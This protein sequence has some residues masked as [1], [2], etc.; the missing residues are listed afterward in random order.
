[1]INFKK[2]SITDIARKFRNNSFINTIYENTPVFIQNL[3]YSS[4]GFFKY[5]EYKRLEMS[6][7][8]YD[9]E[10]KLSIN[11]I[12]KGQV[13]KLKLLLSHASENSVYYNKLLKKSNLDINN[14]KSID[15]LKKIP[16]LDKNIFKENYELIKVTN[17]DKYSPIAMSSGGT[18][19]TSLN[20]LMDK[21]TYLHKE[22]QSIHHW[23]RHGYELGKCNTVMYRAGLII[24]KGKKVANPWRIDYPRK[25][26]YLSSYYASEELYEQYYKLL[27]KWKPKYIHLLPSAV[28]L[29]AKYLNENNL[30]IKLDKA[31]SS[32]ETLYDFQ[33]YEIEKAFQCSIVD[34]YGHIEPGIYVAGQCEEGH[35]HIYTNDVI[36]EVLEDGSLL[37]T[38]LNN[39]SMPFIRYKV[40]DK[41]DGLHDNCSCGINTPYFKTINGR[42]SSIIYTADGRVISSIGFDQ[43]F[44]GNNIRLGQI[45]QNKKGALK[46]NLVVE[47]NYNNNDRDAIISKLQDRV[48]IDTNI[49]VKYLDDIPKAKSGKY[50]LVISHIK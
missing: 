26:I 50:N 45:I 14:I 19:G 9:F 44:R 35:Y 32:S 5:K 48:G 1:M 29:F 2:N 31:F 24:P 23:K 6:L 37:E 42:D 33:K 13:E 40:G 10:E 34:D 39:Y 15:E 25:M 38:S 47:S 17:S 22:C 36:A 27:K 11:D 30:I 20:F 8:E 18:T 21:K 49:E 46:L 3:I 16:I 28:Y 12:K 4:Y 7:G 41:V 43:I